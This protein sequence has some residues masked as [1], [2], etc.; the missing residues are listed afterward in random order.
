MGGELKSGMGW[1]ETGLNLKKMDRRTKGGLLGGNERSLKQDLGP[2]TNFEDNRALGKS[3]L[4]NVSAGS[5][6]LK[7]KDVKEAR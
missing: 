7:S 5:L 2:G 1:L 3:R 6:N 4:G